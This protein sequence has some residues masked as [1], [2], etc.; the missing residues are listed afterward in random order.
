MLAMVI[1]VEV[2]QAVPAMVIPVQGITHVI[3]AD[4]FKLKPKQ[5]EKANQE[6]QP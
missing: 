1:V 2:Q 3:P 4:I 5:N 6:A